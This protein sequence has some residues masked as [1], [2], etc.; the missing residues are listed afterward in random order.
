MAASVVL[1]LKPIGIFGNLLKILEG[2]CRNWKQRVVL[3]VACVVTIKL[4]F[5]D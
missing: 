2:F 3:K 1:K 4:F 5:M